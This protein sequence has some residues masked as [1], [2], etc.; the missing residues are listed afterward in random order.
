M[1]ESIIDWK[2]YFIMN[3]VF[4]ASLFGYGFAITILYNIKKGKYKKDK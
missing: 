2:A 3:F 1:I 4:I